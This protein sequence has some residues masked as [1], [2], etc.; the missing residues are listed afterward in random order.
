MFIINYFQAVVRP[1]ISLGLCLF[2]GCVF[3]LFLVTVLPLLW[4]VTGIWMAVPL[5]EF[6]SLGIGVL[7]I[8]R[9][10]IEQ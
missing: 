4:G 8:K 7:L 9:I 6:I 2:R 5:T 1:R 3:N 10:S